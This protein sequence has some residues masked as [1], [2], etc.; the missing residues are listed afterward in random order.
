VHHRV[1]HSCQV[2]LCDRP[3]AVSESDRTDDTRHRFLTYLSVEASLRR[4]PGGIGDR[5]PADRHDRILTNWHGASPGLFP[6]WDAG[7]LSSFNRLDRAGS[8]ASH[9]TALL[10]GRSLFEPADGTPILEPFD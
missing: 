8:I 4:H 9:H 2:G 3:I 1:A 5:D 10:S 6:I 7:D